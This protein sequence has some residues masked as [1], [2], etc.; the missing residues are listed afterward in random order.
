MDI[1]VNCILIKRRAIITIKQ[2][3]NKKI[4]HKNIEPF[5]L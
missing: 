5:Y 2:I 3:F 1:H 4:D